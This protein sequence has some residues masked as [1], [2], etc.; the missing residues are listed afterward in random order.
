MESIW[1]LGLM[2]GTSLDGIDA[3]LLKTDGVTIQEFGPGLMIPY[4]PFF[5]ERLHSLLQNP[6]S[7]EIG[8]IEQELTDLHTEVIQKLIEQSG[9]KPDLIGFHGQTV[10]HKPR[11]LTANA[12]TLQ[13]GD[14]QRMAGQLGVPVVYDFRRNDVE[15]G[16]EGA[17][18]V[19][20]FHQALAENLS[21]PLAILNIGGVSNV[22]LITEEGIYAGDTGPGGALVDDWMQRHT[23]QPFDKDGQTALQGQVQQSLINKWMEHAFFHHPLPKSLDRQTFYSCL[24]DCRDLTLIDGAAT[25]KAF[26]VEAIKHTLEKHTPVQ[27]ILLTGGGRHSL[28]LRAQLS[29]Y[30]KVKVTEDI[31]WQGDLLE[32]Q[33]F[34]FL[35]VR[36]LYG[37]PLSFPTTTGVSQP[38]TGGKIAYPVML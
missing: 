36:S 9:I 20:V 10:Y 17:P 33:A 23:G 19:P 31:S 11:N 27:E 2:S 8:Q 14:G 1:A 21:K 25:L 4:D 30:F 24:K 22:T 5:R 28:Y 32:A 34:A 26:T 18:F 29:R 6:T 3:A 37:L 12:Q 38:L 7:S 16:G 13:I 35:A 15:N